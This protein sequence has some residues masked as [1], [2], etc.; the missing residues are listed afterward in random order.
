MY[1]VKSRILLSY[2]YINKS[3]WSCN[4]PLIDQS[5]LKEKTKLNDLIRHS[6]IWKWFPF[7]S[8]DVCVCVCVCRLCC[9]DTARQGMVAHLEW[10]HSADIQVRRPGASKQGLYVGRLPSIEENLAGATRLLPCESDSAGMEM[11]CVFTSIYWLKPLE[12][13]NH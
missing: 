7:M 13:C 10:K 8:C 2:I 5:V 4:F 3:L 11:S 9:S 6:H 1:I 12:C